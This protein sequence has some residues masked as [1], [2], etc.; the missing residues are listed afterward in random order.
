MMYL[1][2]KNLLR[3]KARTLLTGGGISVGVVVY[4]ILVSSFAGLLNDSLVFYRLYLTAD[5]TV[6]GGDITQENMGLLEETTRIDYLEKAYFFNVIIV[7][8]QLQAVAIHPDSEIFRLQEALVTG[9]VFKDETDILLPEPMAETLSVDVDDEVFVT[10]MTK[11]QVRRELFHVRGILSAVN[12]G[13]N[14]FIAFAKGE[15]YA[16]LAVPALFLNLNPRYSL[17]STEEQVK[18]L[19]NPQKIEKNETIY[20][21][22]R[23]QYSA[24]YSTA[25]IVSYFIFLIAGLGI[26]NTMTISVVRRKP[27]I[28]ILKSLGMDNTDLFFMF[29]EEGI[30]MALV[31]IL[32]GVGATFLFIQAGKGFIASPL[33]LQ[34]GMIL[35]GVMLPLVIA[36]LFALYPAIIATRQ[37]AMECLRKFG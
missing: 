28:G 14:P 23:N 15:E 13:Y 4:L 35:K 8:Q 7:N 12:V 27:E 36:V 16:D 22:M 25:S 26:L 31:G 17:E 30:L 33:V 37:S 6:V 24:N 18:D 2:W 20:N 5:L 19:F 10:F 1:A 34:L 3:N 32:M 29:L 9:T 11:D 21:A